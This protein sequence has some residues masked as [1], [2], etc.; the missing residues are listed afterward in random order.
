MARISELKRLP[1]DVV[2]YQ[3]FP[4]IPEHTQGDE[5]EDYLE[6]Q[7]SKIL[8]HFGKKLLSYVWQHEPFHLKPVVSN[9]GKKN[10]QHIDLRSIIVAPMPVTTFK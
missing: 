9:Q 6:K 3:I 10:L 8:A 4:H 7:K 5:I 1:E 2:E